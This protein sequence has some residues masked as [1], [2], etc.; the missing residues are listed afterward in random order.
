MSARPPR[1]TIIVGR[2]ATSAGST[3]SGGK[4]RTAAAGSP[5]RLAA[6]AEAAAAAATACIASQET[7]CVFDGAAGAARADIRRFGGRP[8]RPGPGDAAHKASIISRQ[9]GKRCCGSFDRA[10]AIAARS[11]AGKRVQLRPAVQ[12][13]GRELCRRPPSKGSDPVSISW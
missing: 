6:P 9:R 13:L 12:V 11:E 7:S 2:Y 10:L 8:A 1:P 5:G 3:A 4:S